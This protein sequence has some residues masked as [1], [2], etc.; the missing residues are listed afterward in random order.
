MLFLYCLLTV[1]IETPL[2]AVFGWR[3]RKELLRVA[4]V[5]AISNLGL[6]L[7]LA[8]CINDPGFWLLAMEA[9]VVLLEYLAYSRAFGRSA[10]LFFATLS[11]NCISF[12]FGA[13]IFS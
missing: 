1:L 5:N 2:M 6:N 12:G 8:F 13:F 3:L 10:R 7:I 4:V 9:A 11:A